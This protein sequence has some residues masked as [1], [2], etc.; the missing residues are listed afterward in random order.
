[1]APKRKVAAAPAPKKEEVPMIPERKIVVLW[2]DPRSVGT[3]RTGGVRCVVKFISEP[4]GDKIDY[5]YYSPSGDEA[6]YGPVESF[7]HVVV[8]SSRY[9]GPERVVRQPWI[10]EKMERILIDRLENTWDMLPV[11]ASVVLGHAMGQRGCDDPIDTTRWISAARGQRVYRVLDQSRGEFKISTAYEDRILFTCDPDTEG[12][13]YLLLLPTGSPTPP[14][15][16]LEKLVIISTYKDVPEPRPAWMPDSCDWVQ[17]KLDWNVSRVGETYTRVISVVADHVYR[18]GAS[19]LVN[20]L[21][22]RVDAKFYGPVT[23]VFTRGARTS[24]VST[25]VPDVLEQQTTASTAK[26]TTA[27]S[28]PSPCEQTPPSTKDKKEV[29]QSDVVP[30]K[31]SPQMRWVQQ[32]VRGWNIGDDKVDVVTTVLGQHLESHGQT[33]QYTW[34]V[35]DTFAELIAGRKESTAT[36]PWNAFV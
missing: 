15:I 24:S 25:S 26:S 31:P 7:D 1:M 12:I 27:T 5:V 8:F 19:L 21:E 20:S 3:Y 28:E 10:P 22:N 34:F 16:P 2:R 23:W 30:A 36:Q 4:S 11:V 17:I 13:D 6:V 33:P 18:G 29:V 35:V 32:L 14:T 9:S